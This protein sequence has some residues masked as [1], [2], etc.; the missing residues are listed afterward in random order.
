MDGGAKV[1]KHPVDINTRLAYYFVGF[2]TWKLTHLL[3][4]H[5][6]KLSFKQTVRPLKKKKT[7]CTTFVY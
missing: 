3:L 6:I 2:E 5:T 7:H 1:L 4:S